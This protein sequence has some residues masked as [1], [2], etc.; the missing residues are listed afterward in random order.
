MRALADPHAWASRTQTITHHHARQA[1]HLQI[2]ARCR[3]LSG[4]VHLPVHTKSVAD[5]SAG[6]EGSA[7]VQSGMQW[8]S[9]RGMQRA[10]PRGM[11]RA[12]PRAALGPPRAYSQLHL[13]GPPCT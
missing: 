2:P 8:A 13:L 1:T 5:S 12:S 4:R 7:P 11:Q 6:S 3:L 9:P 10:S